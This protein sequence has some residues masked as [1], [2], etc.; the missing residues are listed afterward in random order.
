MKQ[1]KHAG[2]GIREGLVI[3]AHGN[4][5]WVEGDDGRAVPCRN[6]PREPRPVC[7]DRILW[8]ADGADQGHLVEI[9]PRRSELRR[10]EN[11]RGYRVLAANIDIMVVVIA[12]RPEPDPFLIDR[13][14]VAAHVLHLQPAVF[15]N[16]IDLLDAPAR[17]QMQELL[18]EYAV[19]GYPVGTGSAHRNTGIAE[20][21]K[22]LIGKTG[23]LVGQSGV[24]KSSLLQCLVPDA[25]ARIGELSEASG[26]G[27]HTTTAA[28]LYHLP[29]GGDLIDS[30]GVRDFKLWPMSREEIAAGFHEFAELPACR[31]H[32][33]THVHEPGCAVQMAVDQGQISPRR[34]RSYCM[35]LSGAS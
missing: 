19:L 3:A 12:P 28:Q 24:G 16:K 30:P 31:F 11:R 8:R 13:Y 14:L 18:A 1:G 33:C 32:N 34:Y 5:V 29:D 35:A 22:L 10:P 26:E 6:R 23:I 20:L 25:E 27:R 9:L 17:E 4:H 2:D 15:A 7:G 21:R